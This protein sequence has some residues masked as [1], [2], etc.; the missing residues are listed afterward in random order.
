MSD[1]NTNKHTIETPADL[2]N[3]SANPISSMWLGV[4][5]RIELLTAYELKGNLVNNEGLYPEDCF[6][7]ISVINA[8]SCMHANGYLNKPSQ[9]EL[10]EITHATNRLQIL[11]FSSTGFVSRRTLR[12]TLNQFVDLLVNESTPADLKAGF[13]KTLLEI[14]HD[15][16]YHSD[17]KQM[18]LDTIEQLITYLYSKQNN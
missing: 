3:V 8:L 16:N 10:E 11:T 15:G 6:G 14:L 9:D 13:H 5:D 17:S 18:L 4:E 12:P 1:K 7:V 2:F